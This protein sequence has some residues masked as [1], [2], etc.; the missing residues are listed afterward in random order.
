M[1][2]PA[3]PALSV[4]IP[5]HNRRRLV[6]E[7]IQ[8][9]GG[10]SLP[11]DQFE[12]VVVCDGDLDG[13]EGALGGLTTGFTL[14]VVVQP[15]SGPA[16]AR[17]RGVENS[18]GGV[19]LFLDDD[20]VAEPELL[21]EHLRSHAGHPERVVVGRLLPDPYVKARGW[22]LW[23]QRNFDQRYDV[24][25]AGLSQVDGRKFYSGNASVSRTAF[26]AV[27]GFDTAYRRAEDIELGYRLQRWGADFR[28]N[29][30]AACVHRGVHSF[31]SWCRIQY[32]YGRCDVLM[33][34][35]HDGAYRIPLA[36]WFRRRNVFN[37]LLCRAAVGRPR[38]SR[39][40][41]SACRG[42]AAGADAVRAAGVGRWAYSAIAN[43]QYWQ[44]VADELGGGDRLWRLLDGPGTRTPVSG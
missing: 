38:T 21:A 27:G 12:V 25:A 9:L 23:E 40:L 8:S 7:T 19:L 16:A 13:T 22:T 43:L 39:A 33:A 35:A 29:G 36:A 1:I 14:K 3:K 44:G 37:R 24:L 15:Q 5:T 4:V 41:H 34:S 18:R 2:A 17:N 20:I 28:F 11:A 31:E 32:T 26:E 30:R 42:V 10:Q 6:G